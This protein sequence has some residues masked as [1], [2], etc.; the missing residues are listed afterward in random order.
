MMG[1]LSRGDDGKAA[2]DL[3]KV[4]VLRRV[5]LLGFGHVP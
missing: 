2:C 4:L 1:L 3:H 5:E